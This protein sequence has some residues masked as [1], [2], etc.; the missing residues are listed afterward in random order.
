MCLQYRKFACGVLVLRILWVEGIIGPILFIF[1]CCC[2]VTKSYLTLCDPMD[3]RLPC[4]PTPGACSNSCPSCWWC[5]P[6]ISS[7]VV[8]FSSCL[9]SFPALG[10]FPVSQ[11]FTSGG[12]NTGASASVLLM[13]IQSWFPLGLT[14]HIITDYR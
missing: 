13:N 5:H 1:M 6:T 7:S 4:P 12:Q 10:S 8:P 11:F 9:Q 3:S 2:S 14:I